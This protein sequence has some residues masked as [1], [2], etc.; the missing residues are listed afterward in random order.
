MATNTPSLKGARSGK[1]S[2]FSAQ[3]PAGQSPLVNGTKGIA[4]PVGP[5]LGALTHGSG[6]STVNSTPTK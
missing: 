6:M 1:P 3:L 5:N 2:G 4:A